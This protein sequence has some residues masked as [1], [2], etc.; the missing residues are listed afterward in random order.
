[1]KF[2][3][4]C[5]A[6]AILSLTGCASI[7]VKNVEKRAA[8]VPGPPA[9]IHVA[10]YETSGGNW[11]ITSISRKPEQYKAEVAD[12]LAK[13]L[14]ADLSAFLKVPVQRVGR[15]KA[16]P[17]NGWLVTG[18]FTRVSEGNPAG[19]IIVGLGVGGTKL[20]TDTT[21]LD[22]RVHGPF[23][24][25]ATTGGSNA[26]PGVL[27]SSGPGSAVVTG[28]TAAMRGVS[29]D[30]KRTSRQ[31]TAALAEYEVE[32]GW[33]KT[34]SLKVKKPGEYQLLQP[35]MRPATATSPAKL[36]Q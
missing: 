4:L 21:V 7:S 1:M 3:P 2:F 8:R 16:V 32:K 19:R 11:K 9:V 23:L 24:H 18:R 35:M 5:A 14:A 27:L 10:D 13:E 29:D 34:T 30:A 15:S 20:E 25:F 31:V 33:M 28:V 26:T 36:H 17:P 22:G 6:A 12:I